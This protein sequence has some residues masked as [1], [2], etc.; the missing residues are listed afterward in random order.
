MNEATNITLVLGGARSGKS[1]F[2]EQLTTESGKSLLYFATAEAWDDEMKQR[3]QLHQ[4]QRGSGWKTIEAPLGLAEQLI[5]HSDSD[6]TILVDCLTLWLSN[7]MG[8]ERDINSEFDQL[9]KCLEKLQG[10][11]IFVSNEVGQGIVPDNAMAR[12]FR[13]HAGRLHQR[14]AGKA[15]NVYFVTAGIAQ[16]IK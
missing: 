4:E 7:L 2:A 10:Q 15:D 8:S 6:T 5:S 3:I 16:K 1:Q 14:I 13:D 11:I 9:V 12:Q